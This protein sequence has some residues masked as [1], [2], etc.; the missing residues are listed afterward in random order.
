MRPEAKLGFCKEGGGLESK[1]CCFPQKLS[2]L[3]PVLNKLMQVKRIK[4]EAS[5][6]GGGGRAFSR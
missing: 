4:K 5:G 1:F 6:G 3:G 2:N